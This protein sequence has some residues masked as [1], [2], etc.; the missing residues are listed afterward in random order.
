MPKKRK[1]IPPAYLLFTLTTMGLL[2]CLMPVARLVALPYSY[3]GMPLLLA[4]ICL[5]A[6][7]ARAFSKAGTSLV[8]FE[9]S[10]ALLTGGLYR[11]TRNPMYLG[12]VLVAL[13]AWV[14]LGTLSALFPIA[15]FITIIEFHFIRD[16]ER[17][18][19]SI[20]GGDYLGYKQRVRRWI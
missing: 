10:T 5:T 20:F 4:G 18:L 19:E 8:P 17:F 7:A 1:L 14:L 16:E 11:Y 3:L 12:L 6:T 9:P 13:G 15:V 2:H